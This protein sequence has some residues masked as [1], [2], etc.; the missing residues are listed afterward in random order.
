MATTT[1]SRPAPFGAIATHTLV[2]S[3]EDAVQSV[4]A[5]NTQRKTRQILSALTHEELD[6]IGLTRT[7]L[8]TTKRF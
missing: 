6:D 7:A 8:K 4:V 2:C 3:V 5:W 1:F